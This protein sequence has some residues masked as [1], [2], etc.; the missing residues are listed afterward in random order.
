M[1]DSL[2]VLNSD[3]FFYFF[4]CIHFRVIFTKKL[5]LKNKFQTIKHT[6]SVPI[7]G[8]LRCSVG[9]IEGLKRKGVKERV[10]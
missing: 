4:Y 9:F 10:D 5:E 3:H 7:T 1:S 6:T 2:K 8:I